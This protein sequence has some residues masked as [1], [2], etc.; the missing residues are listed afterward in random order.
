[1]AFHESGVDGICEGEFGEI[2]HDII[3]HLVGLESGWGK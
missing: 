1:M 2:F 3:L